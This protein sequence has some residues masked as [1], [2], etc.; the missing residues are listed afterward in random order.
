[1]VPGI[2][3]VFVECAFPNR[4]ESLADIS[5]HM[6]PNRLRRERDKMPADVP[7]FVYHIKPQF[8]QETGDEL[9]SL[10][11]DVSVVEQDKTYTV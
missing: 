3:A 7:I 9:A 1:M 5:R 4:L 2:R 6:T 10:G 11:D 8:T